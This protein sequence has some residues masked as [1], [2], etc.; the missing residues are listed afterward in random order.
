MAG[1][2][3]RNSFHRICETRKDSWRK[4]SLSLIEQWSKRVNGAFEKQQRED[5]RQVK[6]LLGYGMVQ[7]QSPISQRGMY[8]KEMENLDSALRT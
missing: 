5:N 2:A 3:T 8:S 7:N 4:I 6:L 1:L